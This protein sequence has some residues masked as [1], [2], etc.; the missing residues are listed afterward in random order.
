MKIALSITALVASLI[1]LSTIDIN[2]LKQALLTISALFIEIM[3]LM[4]S[5]MA[6]AKVKKGKNKELTQTKEFT[7][8]TVNALQA[9]VGLGF[10][11]MMF[12]KSLKM[13]SLAMLLLVKMA[14]RL[15]LSNRLTL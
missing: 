11:M 2:K 7:K 5:I 3:V 10:T 13:L 12:A 1:V 15:K 14:T 9:I 4:R 8:S 6:K